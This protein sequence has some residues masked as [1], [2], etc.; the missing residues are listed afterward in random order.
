MHRGL[1]DDSD[2]FS[3]EIDPRNPRQ[4]FASACS[5]I[6][7]SRDRGSNWV[8]LVGIPRDSRRTY[9]IR[10]DPKHEAVIYAGTSRGLWKSMDRG[11][12]WKEISPLI[13]RAIAF[14]PRDSRKFV[15]ATE[16]TG[17]VVTAAGGE[18]THPAVAFAIHQNE[19]YISGDEG[20]TWSAVP[21][22]RPERCLVLALAID[23]EDPDYLYALAKG[24][25]VFVL[26]LVGNPS[27]TVGARKPN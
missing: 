13:V 24:R 14:D 9:T 25:G 11:L 10:Q 12:S 16:N 17:L 7:T 18:T 26:S 6:Y 5:G 1:I 19:L 22:T 8:K 20:A 2:V 15:M 27:I 4:I 3:L 21:S 23:L